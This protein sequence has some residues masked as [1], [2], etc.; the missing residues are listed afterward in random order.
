MAS[1]VRRTYACPKCNE[2]FTKWG[3]C[4]G[5]I[6]GSTS[7]R[8]ALADRLKDIDALQELCRETTA[9]I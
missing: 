3:L 7:C 9:S 5:H 4:Q 8:D 6:R 1:A 2:S